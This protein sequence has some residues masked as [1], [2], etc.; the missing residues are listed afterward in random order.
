[1][2]RCSDTF[3]TR[4]RYQR[5]Q[6]AAQQ[7]EYLYGVSQVAAALASQK[8]RCYKI[9][10]QDSN[11][12]VKSKH[13]RFEA[14]FTQAQELGLGI[15][16]TNKADLNR[17]CQNRPH[18]GVVLQCSS[19]PVSRLMSL[20]SWQ[21]HQYEVILSNH[22]RVRLA[23]TPPPVWLMLD[24][25]MDPQNVGSI[26]R[27]AYFLGADGV[28]MSARDSAPLNPTVAKASSG[29]LE[30]VNLYVT[31]APLKTLLA[32]QA[33]GWQIIG[34]LLSNT[35]TPLSALLS[36]TRPTILV[37]GSEGEGLRSSLVSHCD[38]LVHLPQ[39]TAANTA[40]VDSLNVSVA[41]GIFL[42][43]L[44]NSRTP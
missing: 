15:E 29:A 28:V 24:R 11:D 42:Q 9:Y 4:I 35:S 44:L 39:A 38:T 40:L 2:P 31:T 27:T 14:V 18:Q 17:L 20:S 33:Q 7:A 23:S 43:Q 1:M 16:Y 3:E 26:L 36:L 5:H 41:T 21:N 12:L 19:L 37:M 22:S 8:R 6:R 10:R 32:C 13:P 30:V 25:I 34:T